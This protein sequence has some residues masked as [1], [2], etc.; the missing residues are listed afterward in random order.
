MDDVISDTNDRERESEKGEKE[1]KFPMVA[2]RFLCPF[3]S[4]LLPR[5]PNMY[6]QPVK[7]GKGHQVQA[8]H[9][10]TTLMLF[11]KN[12]AS[13]TLFINKFDRNEASDKKLKTKSQLDE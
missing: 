8:L 2:N 4:T 11:I 7:L 13:P 10:L 1:R 9:H 3:H 12:I 6:C 5:L